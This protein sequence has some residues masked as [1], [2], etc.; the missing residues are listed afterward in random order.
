MRPF[1]VRFLSVLRITGIS[2][3]MRARLLVGKITCIEQAAFILPV[4]I[5]VLV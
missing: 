3:L 5:L 2:I 1:P 4:I